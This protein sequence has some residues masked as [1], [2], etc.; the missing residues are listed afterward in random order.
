MKTNVALTIVVLLTIGSLH[1]YGQ[2]LLGVRGGHSISGITFTPEQDTRPLTSPL[3]DIGLIIKHFDL[4]H[5]GF[6]GELNYTQRGYL[7][8][9]DSS[10]Y[11]KRVNSFVEMPLFFQIRAARNNFFGHINIG[12]CASI[13]THSK[14][15]QNADLSQI[16]LSKYKLNILRDNY[17]NYGLKG[18]VGLGYD[19]S[20]GTIQFDIRYLY[21]LGDLYYY[22]YSG[23]PSRSPAW[24]INSSLSFMINLSNSKKEIAIFEDNRDITNGINQI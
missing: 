22:N 16:E 24:A 7:S 6:Q 2:L 9:V 12:F 5:V 19:F 20:W 4:E 3:I 10:Y 8:F 13:I 21:G 18:G 14:A 23:N 17:F 1:S 15:G 11:Y